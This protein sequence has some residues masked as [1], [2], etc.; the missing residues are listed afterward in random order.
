MTFV[1][2]NIIGPLLYLPYVL[3]RICKKELLPKTVF[4][5]LVAPV[6]WGVGFVAIFLLT[7]F[8]ISRLPFDSGIASMI[9]GCALLGGALGTGFSFCSFAANIFS[10]QAR[11]EFESKLSNYKKVNKSPERAQA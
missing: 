3:Y 5:C 9:L 2:F 6:A 8:I 1:F 7:G 4:V 11:N 10:K